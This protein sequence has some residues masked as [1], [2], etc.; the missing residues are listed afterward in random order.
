MRRAVA[1]SVYCESIP[2]LS[3]LPMDDGIL[4]VKLLPAWSPSSVRAELTAALSRSHLLQAAIAYWTVPDGLLGPHLV[5]ALND[6]SGFVCVD[7]HRPTEVEAL[8]SFA[9]QGAHVYIYYEDI[10]T[11]TDQGRK[12]PPCLLHSKLLLFW[13]K[14]RTAELW[15]GSHNWTNRAILGLN[16]EASLVVRLRDSSAL[17]AAAAEYLGK[18]K[19]IS[20]AFDPAKVDLYKEMQRK[21]SLG[22]VPVIEL[23]AENSGSHS[24]ATITVF[25]TDTAELKQ[26]GTIERDVN[27]ALFD[28]NSEKQE[29]YP[30]IILQSGLLSASDPSADGISFSPRRHAFRRGR[31]FA[32]LLPPKPIDQKVLKTAQYFVTLRLGNLNTAQ[33][34]DYPPMRTVVFEEMGDEDSPLLERLDPDARKRLFRGK[35]PRVKRPATLL[36]DVRP[37]TLAERRTL[38]EHSL[39]SM[40][41]LRPKG[42]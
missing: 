34:A 21:I 36:E 8:A 7:L 30:A 24:G 38:P 15:V 17:F 3:S 31:R 10:P 42:P 12:E 19:K 9:S 18:M 37:Q 26:V 14:D 6:N 25:G 32:L 23:E 33:V 41:V 27:V 2:V 16:V 39:V 5:R 29:L 40:R 4:N 11:Y 22:L 28:P 1:Q 20:E 35:E 13:S